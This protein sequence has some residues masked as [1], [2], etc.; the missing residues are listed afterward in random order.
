M[1]FPYLVDGIIAA[2]GALAAARIC[3]QTVSY[4]I[5]THVSKEPA[6]KMILEEL[7]L[8]PLIDCGMCLGE[9]TGD[10]S[11]ATV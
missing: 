2:A 9:G 4:M 3:P 6:G 1:V 7:G 10:C 5:A 8:N 11:Y